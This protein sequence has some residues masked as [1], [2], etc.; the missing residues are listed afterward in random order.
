MNAAKNQ[1]TIKLLLI[2]TRV[3]RELHLAAFKSDVNKKITWRCSKAK[4]EH[5]NVISHRAINFLKR[6]LETK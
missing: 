5:S 6:Q 2:L 3:H 1:V 4:T